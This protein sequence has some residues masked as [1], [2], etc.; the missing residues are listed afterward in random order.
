M[1]LR[2]NPESIFRGWLWHKR[3]RIRA[4]L[5]VR[6][7]VDRAW[8]I[9]SEHKRQIVVSRSPFAPSTPLPHH[10]LL[11]LPPTRTSSFH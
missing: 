9:P 10:H 1:R 5:C 2:V 4:G 8:E 7:V 3:I 11:L 6:L